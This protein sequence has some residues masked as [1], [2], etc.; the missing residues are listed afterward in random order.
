MA[1]RQVRRLVQQYFYWAAIAAALVVLALLARGTWGVY[2][3]MQEAAVL[4]AHAVEERDTLRGQK[5][6]LEGSLQRI[7]T[8]RGVEEEIR[9]RYPYVRPGERE[10]VLVDRAAT[11]TDT[12][13][14]AQGG[15]WGTV[16]GWF[17]L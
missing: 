5:A 11:S 13:M 9:E 12:K 6:E 14:P 1:T 16:G 15:F 3:K 17:G 10:F 7:K 4:K 8:A 2:S